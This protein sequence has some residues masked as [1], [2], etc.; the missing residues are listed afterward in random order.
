MWAT[1]GQAAREQRADYVVAVDVSGSMKRFRDVV[2]P[3]VAAFLESLPDG[4]YV[5]I[6]AFGTG[7]RLVS[8][9]AQVGPASRP[10]IR[11]SLDS[12]AFADQ[13]TDLSAMARQVL[14][15]LN[16]P[17]GSSLKFVFAFTDFDHDPPA[18][19]RGR[20]EWERLKDRFQAENAGRKVEFFA[21]K[22]ALSAKSGRDLQKVEGI[23]PGLQIIPVNPATLGGWFQRRKAENL[24][25]RLKHVVERSMGDTAPA[26]SANAS[27][28]SVAVELS[29]G[30]N[31]LLGSLL[32]NSIRASGSE[33]PISLVSSPLSVKTG[34]S[35][36]IANYSGG[37]Y[38][39][40]PVPLGA[41][42]IS[43]AWETSV[44][45]GEIQRLGITLPESPSLITVG[46]RIDPPGTFEFRISNNRLEGRARAPGYEISLV[47]VRL[48]ALESL[49]ELN[50]EPWFLNQEWQGFGE[51]P[52]SGTLGKEFLPGEM[53]AVVAFVTSRETAVIGSPQTIP[54]DGT[55]V[56]GRFALWQL[57]AVAAL[58]TAIL[59]YLCFAYRPGRKFLGKLVFSPRDEEVLL[60]SVSKLILAADSS[61]RVLRPV[62]GDIPAQ[63][64]LALGTVGSVVN[65]LSGRRML[66]LESGEA[67]LVYKTG[68]KEKNVR[69]SRRQRFLL[70][71]DVR[72]F[73]VKSGSWSARWLRTSR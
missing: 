46:G 60:K 30:S 28:Q 11:S 48:P 10:S 66:R 63:L 25:D 18:A 32:I 6:I 31:P 39:D 47:D 50:P 59:L 54:V 53:Q 19:T 7:A 73:Q 61:D 57:V 67:E 37:G 35:A 17:A 41:F 9:P 43:T 5:S 21:M 55:V 24:R 40:K 1:Y 52:V 29:E 36:Q 16:R 22:L 27:G 26:L 45:L 49:I 33:V 65:P 62:A 2:V 20:E 38:F 58:L 13:N 70:P 8:V 34:G 4:D 44:D 15:E 64:R 69:L 56:L 42:Q 3:N 23:F 68:R 51:I 72:E 71:T 12:I 14:D